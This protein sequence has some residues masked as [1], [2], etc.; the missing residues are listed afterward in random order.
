M[1]KLLAVKFNKFGSRS[2]FFWSLFLFLLLNLQAA[3][4]NSL[5]DLIVLS[6]TRK[7]SETKS[8]LRLLHYN[9]TLLGGYESEADG[10]NFF[11]DKIHGKSDPQK[12]LEADLRAFFNSDLSLGN[13]HAIC[14]YPAR[15]KWL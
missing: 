7:L 2:L 6:S 13:N 1:I 11:Q 10:M 14:L 3:T 9:K 15:L 12:E 4:Y 5:D 8:W